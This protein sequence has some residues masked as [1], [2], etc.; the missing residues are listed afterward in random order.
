[1]ERRRIS[2]PPPTLPTHAEKSVQGSEEIPL[3]K[4]VRELQSLW[5]SGAF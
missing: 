2:E 4:R 3:P 1:V 5:L